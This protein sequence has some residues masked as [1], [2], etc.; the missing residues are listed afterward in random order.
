MMK[1]AQGHIASWWQNRDVFYYIKSQVVGELTHIF[2]H[3]SIYLTT[4][5]T[6]PWA[7]FAL[8]STH[9][10]LGGYCSPSYLNFVV[11]I[12]V[13]NQSCCSP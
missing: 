3:I 13:A 9:S 7:L 12:V 5:G 1:A 6:V 8:L 10:F 11:L 2:L 4:Y